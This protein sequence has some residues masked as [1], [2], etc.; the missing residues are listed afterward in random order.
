MLPSD[1]GREAHE[2][3]RLQAWLAGEANVIVRRSRAEND[4]TLV[5]IFVN[6]TRRFVN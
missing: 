2:Q 4:R 6:P 5:G 1:E 3:R